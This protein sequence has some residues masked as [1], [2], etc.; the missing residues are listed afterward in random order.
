MNFEQFWKKLQLELKQEKEFTTLKQNKK[1]KVRLGYVEDKLV[2][3]IT[4][5]DSQIQRGRIPRNEF[6][7]IWNNAKIYSPETRFVNKN[8]RL[9]SFTNKNGTKGKSMQVSYI[10]TLIKHIVRN[11][12]MI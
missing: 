10:V 11:Q 3:L 5:H 2:V 4:P 12:E 8:K 7:G 1:F 9:E 6:E